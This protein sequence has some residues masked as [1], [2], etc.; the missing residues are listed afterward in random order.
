MEALRL[1]IHGALGPSASCHTEVCPFPSQG[2]Q[3]WRISPLESLTTYRMAPVACEVSQGTDPG[4]HPLGGTEEGHGISLGPH[5]SQ[6]ME[7]WRE[8]PSSS[9]HQGWRL[10]SGTKSKPEPQKA[11]IGPWP[12]LGKGWHSQ[13]SFW[14]QWG[15][16][17]PS[18]A[19]PGGGA[20]SPAFSKGKESTAK[21]LDLGA[22]EDCLHLDLF[23]FP[24]R[25]PF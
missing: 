9:Q 18:S 5:C 3:A 15:Q 6:P 11:A 7:L 12:G 25:K 16:S 19:S 23:Y 1:S 21:N 17:R 4:K 13:K 24:L 8:V 14:L 20:L 22:G 2:V 10:P